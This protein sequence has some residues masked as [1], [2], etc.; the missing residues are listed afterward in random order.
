[1]T[2]AIRMSHYDPIQLQFE[3]LKEV[4]VDDKIENNRIKSS[5]KKYCGRLKQMG[6]EILLELKKEQVRIKEMCW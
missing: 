5:M 4:K 3:V 2:N 1:M 6:K